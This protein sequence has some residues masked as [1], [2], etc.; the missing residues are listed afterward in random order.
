MPVFK[1]G[2]DSVTA[3]TFRDS[4]S[5]RTAR[6]SCI[7]RRVNLI[8]VVP[9]WQ[10]VIHVERTDDDDLRRLGHHGARRRSLLRFRFIIPPVPDC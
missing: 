8:D 4:I 2:N 3:A 10:R 9:D 5:G 7:P 6:G 1:F